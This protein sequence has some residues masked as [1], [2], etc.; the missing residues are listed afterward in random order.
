MMMNTRITRA[1]KDVRCKWYYLDNLADLGE[2]HL[3][4]DDN[5]LPVHNDDFPVE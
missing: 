3:N 4:E 2:E 5:D 1:Y